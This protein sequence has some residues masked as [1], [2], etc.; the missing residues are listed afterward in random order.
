MIVY[1]IYLPLR[2]YVTGPGRALRFHN[3]ERQV[4]TVACYSEQPEDESMNES[5]KQLVQAFLDAIGRG[6]PLDDMITPDMTAWTVT[7]GATD[8]ARFL[9]AVKLLASIFG[10]GLRYTIDELTVQGDRTVA[11]VRS[12]GTLPDSGAFE[13]VHVFIFRLRDGRIASVAEFMNQFVV[14]DRI[15]PLMQAALGEV[16]K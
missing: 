11:E 9:G 8:Q 4:P 13:N 1:T 14:K 12:H 3:R 6:E 16:P 7:A 5:E 2:A 15:V 10:G